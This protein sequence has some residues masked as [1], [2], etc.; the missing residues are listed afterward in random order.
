MARP[1]HRGK[2][3]LPSLPVRLRRCE[4]ADPLPL[5]EAQRGLE[6][7]FSG[8]LVGIGRI[9]LADPGRMQRLRHPPFAISAPLQGGGPSGGESG[10]VDI[11]ERLQAFDERV[12]LC[13]LPLPPP[14]P[15]LAAEI[16]SELGARGRVAPDIEEREPFNRFRIQRRAGL[17]V[18]FRFHAAI[19]VP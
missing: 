13:R 9:L 4:R 14:L 7:A 18:T 10:I 6:G 2:G 16:G 12:K 19:I 15:H 5:R 11:A 8:Q 1:H 17:F 3:F